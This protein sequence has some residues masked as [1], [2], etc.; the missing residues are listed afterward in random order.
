M[1]LPLSPITGL[2]RS[3]LTLHALPTREL[4]ARIFEAFGMKAEASQPGLIASRLIKQMGGLQRCR[5]FK[6]AGVRDSID[7]YG[8][9]DSFTKSGAIQIIGQNDPAT[10]R[11][12]FANFEGLFIEQR[13]A[14]KLKPEHAFAFLLRNRVFRPGLKLKCIHCQLDYWLALDDIATEVTCE[15]C[16]NAFNITAQLHDRDWA[17]RRSG[18]FGREDHQQGS[19]PV[20]ITLQQLDTML[21]TEMIYTTAMNIS[22]VSADIAPCE[23][24]FVVV[25]QP[26]YERR[27]PLAIGECKAKG[28]ITEG[29]V[30]NLTKVADAFRRMRIQPFIVFAKTASFTP[31]ETVRCQTAQDQYGL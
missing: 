26:N 18:L 30:R 1:A 25:G 8:S 21:S 13:K 22:P 7:K 16:G 27:V 6:I 31:E 2:T 9:L 4:I 29:D 5:V 11:P 14:P 10:G 20:A 23:T 24:D 15:L 19:I 28:E 3:D 12:N 17:Y